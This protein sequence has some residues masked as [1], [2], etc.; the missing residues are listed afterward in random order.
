MTDAVCLRC[1]AS[2]RMPQRRCS[3]CGWDPTEDPDTDALVKSVYLSI[4]RFE[5]VEDQEAYRKILETTGEAIRSGEHPGFDEAEIERLRR[6]G[7]HL[8]PAKPLGRGCLVG[9]IAA[10]LIG[11]GVAFWILRELG[12]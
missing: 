11:G 12:W 5:K 10:A 2:K 9:G 8:P 1:G 6:S 7:A 4:G 3:G